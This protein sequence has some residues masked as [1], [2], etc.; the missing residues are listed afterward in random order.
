MTLRLAY[1]P[2][3]L[4]CYPGILRQSGSPAVRQSGSRTIRKEVESQ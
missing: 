4:N 3:P 1:N 2:G